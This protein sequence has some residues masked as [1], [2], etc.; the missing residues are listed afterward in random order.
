LK[1]DLIKEITN[2][3]N[4]LRDFILAQWARELIFGR[5][6][7]IVSQLDKKLHFFRYFLKRVS[8]F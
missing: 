2:S 3:N 4:D 8:F 5:K 7:G 6:S 1:K